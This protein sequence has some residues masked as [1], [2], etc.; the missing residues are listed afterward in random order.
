MQG[1]SKIGAYLLCILNGHQQLAL[2]LYHSSPTPCSSHLVTIV[3]HHTRDVR[4]RFDSHSNPEVAEQ[5]SYIAT[6]NIYHT[7]AVI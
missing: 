2:L 3:E 6:N 5:D 4:C 1:Y 7:H